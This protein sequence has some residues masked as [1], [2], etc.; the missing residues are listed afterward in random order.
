LPVKGSNF[1]IKPLFHIYSKIDNKRLVEITNDK[2]YSKIVD[3]PSK[4]FISMEQFAAYCYSEGNFMWTGVKSNFQKILQFISA[5]FPECKELKTL[6]W[7]REGFYAFANG[8]YNGVW[9]P[10][11]DLGIT[12]HKDKNYFSRPSQW[13]MPT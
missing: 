2:G 4:N 9:Q 11:D 7:R 1:I 6:G 5:D 13:Y 10:V 8:I 3:I 12:T